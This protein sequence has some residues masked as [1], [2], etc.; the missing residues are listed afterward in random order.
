MNVQLPATLSAARLNVMNFLNEVVMWYPNAISFAPGRPAEQH[1]DVASS[2]E[3]LDRY[4][5][6]VAEQRGLP[7]ATIYGLL[8][9]YG[10]TNGSINELV[11]RFLAQDERIEVAPSAVMIT[12]GGQEGMTIL[13]AGLFDPARDV[14][15]TADPTYIGMT[16]I[17]TILGI[18]LCPVPTTDESI[19]LQAL[20]QAVADVRARGKNPRALYLVPDFNNPLGMSMSLAARQELLALARAHELLI[21]EDNPYGMF[22]YD[23]PPAPTLKALDRDGVVI[24]LGTFSKILYPGLRLGFL[25][26]DQ[27]VAG[28]AGERP[29]TLAEELSKVKSLTSVNT[30]SLLQG[31][32]GGVL[33]EHECS[34]TELMQPKIAFYRANRDLMLRSLQQNIDAD[35]LLAGRVSWNQPG[36]GFFITV[37]LPFAFSEELLRVCA[38][39]YGVICCPISFF[40]LLPG[41]EHQIRLSFSYVTP[42]QIE[43]G[44]RQL[45]QFIHDQIAAASPAA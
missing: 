42:A 26:A 7:P 9:Q 41:R 17:A 1:F 18:E 19:D 29:V 44:I 43:R 24:Y 33:L 21:I 8:G 25:V 37:T 35:P 20:A 3:S 38:E 16:G 13:A 2:F 14:L 12:D 27:I 6:H 22:A 30:S 34:L 36:G 23:G 11:C 10:K 5:T 4:V 15:L 32:V 31:I 40:S 28:G 39:R 45:C